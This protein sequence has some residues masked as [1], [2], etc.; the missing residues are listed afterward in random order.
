MEIYLDNC[1]TT[2][3]C[4]EAVQACIKAMT[5]DYGNPSSLHKKGMEAEEILRETRRTAAGIL[6]CDANLLTITGSA[7]E[8]NNLAILGAAAAYPRAGKTIVT[9]SVEHASVT[10]AVRHLAENG[11][12]IR[13]VNPR[14]DGN[15]HPQ[16]FLDA[17]DEDTFLLS[18]MMVN[19]EIGTIL[20]WQ[21]VIPALRKK[22]PKLLIHM[23]AVQGFAKYP[24]NVKR[25]DLD[26][27]SLSGHKI[28]APKGVGMLYCKKGIR[29]KPIVFGGGQENGLRSGTQAVQLAA[30]LTEAMR[31]CQQNRTAF[32]AHYRML[33]ARLRE[34]VA[35][36]D[37]VC[38][39]SPENG[40]P[41][42]LNISV[43]GVPSEIML[44]FLESK[45]IF[46]SSGSAC[47]KGAKSEVLKAYGFPEERIRSALRIS[48]SKD[49]TLEDIDLLS[50]ALIEGAARFRRMTGA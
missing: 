37:R 46:V 14:S 10:N 50:E 18:M 41:H 42:L 38:I 39:N 44:H 26:L 13:F 27:L 47:S 17:V 21:T 12:N 30:G 23:D 49:N 7:T 22:Y 40:A 33:N 9:T 1:A 25:L 31:L 19:N 6:G 8:S 43:I 35:G 11:Y 15:F 3:V 32:E 5:L 45:G 28:Y 4:D 34:K 2:R 29:L 16:D 20:P 36:M 48:F 24:L